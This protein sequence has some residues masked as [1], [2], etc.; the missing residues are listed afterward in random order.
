[1][2]SKELRSKCNSSKVREEMHRPW[3]AVL[4]SIAHFPADYLRELYSVLQSPK[5]EGNP[6]TRDD[7]YI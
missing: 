6:K 4:F 1:M 7:M 5:W 3:L 2:K